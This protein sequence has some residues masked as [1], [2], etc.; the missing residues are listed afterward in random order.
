MYPRQ[1]PSSESLLVHRLLPAGEV[2]RRPRC[3]PSLGDC[4]PD[5][6]HE[7]EVEMQVVNGV[8][9]GPENLVATVEVAEVRPG[10]VPAGV[11][12]ADGVDGA[13]I[14]LV[15]AVADVDDTR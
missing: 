8:Q 13:E 7:V 14:G 9:T 1:H 10:V 6:P 4:R 15:N 3:K 11:A 2:A 5:R 12:A